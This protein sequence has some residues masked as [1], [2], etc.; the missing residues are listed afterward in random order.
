MVDE[1]VGADVRATDVGADVGCTGVVGV[2]VVLGGGVR[3]PKV[4]TPSVPSGIWTTDG[5]QTAE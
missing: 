3:P 4:Q 1:T 2:G 5:Q